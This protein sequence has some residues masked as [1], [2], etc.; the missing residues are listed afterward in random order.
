MNIWNSL[1]NMYRNMRALSVAVALFAAIIVMQV[2]RCNPMESRDDIMAAVLAVEAEGL[3]PAGQGERQSRVL[4]ITPDSLKV[5]LL[6]PPPVPGVGDLIPLVAE[7]YKKGDTLFFLDQQK[8]RMN[9]PQQG[10]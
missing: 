3:Q 7:H 2:A 10:Q 1:A 6:L 9:G 8:W 5:R 4:V